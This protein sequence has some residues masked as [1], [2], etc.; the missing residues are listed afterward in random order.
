MPDDTHEHVALVE[1]ARGGDAAAFAG[2]IA[3]HERACLA[4]AYAKLRHADAAGDVVQEAFLKAWQNIKSLGSAASFG[5]WLGQIVRN[6]ATDVQRSRMRQAEMGIVAAT[7]LTA[8]AP[9]GEGSDPLAIVARK[10]LAG[11]VDA[12]LARLDE[13]TREIVTLRY[14]DGLASRE[15]GALV[16]MSPAAVDMRLSRARAELR[17]MLGDEAQRHEGTQAQRAHARKT[18]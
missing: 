12:A 7:E 8:E 14:F 18:A 9:A 1:R 16:G 6:L 17:E 11:V 15:I 4:I 10:E 3:R 13:T 5:P 2:L